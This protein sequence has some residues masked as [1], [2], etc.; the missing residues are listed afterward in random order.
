MLDVEL[1]GDRWCGMKGR[2]RVK[3][4]GNEDRVENKGKGAEKKQEKDHGG[5]SSNG[6]H[7]EGRW[8]PQFKF[9]LCGC[10]RI[11]MAVNPHWLPH[12]DSCNGP[13]WILFREL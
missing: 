1:I 2:M 6:F 9:M 7:T 8:R 5:V 11:R 3:E 13:D 10:L 4:N 12:G